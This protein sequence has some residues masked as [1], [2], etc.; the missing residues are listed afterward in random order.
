[1]D[2]VPEPG[3]LWEIIVSGGSRN[4]KTKQL[5]LVKKSEMTYTFSEPDCSV[6]FPKP[7]HIPIPKCKLVRRIQEIKHTKI[8]GIPDEYYEDK[9]DILTQPPTIYNWK[10]DKE[11]YINGD[12]GPN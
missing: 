9:N 5:R 6:Y 11:K 4:E 8:N 3:E 10:F 2:L 12:I 1:M 7:I